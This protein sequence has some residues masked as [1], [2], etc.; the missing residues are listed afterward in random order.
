MPSRSFMNNKARI[1]LTCA[2]TKLQQKAQ[3]VRPGTFHSAS[4]EFPLCLRLLPVPCGR[5]MRA[6]CLP[7]T[8]SKTFPGALPPSPA[9]E[10]FCPVVEDNPQILAMWKTPDL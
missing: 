7:R 4:E 9:P 1:E 2:Q 6:A 3:T 10:Q 8:M 5:Q